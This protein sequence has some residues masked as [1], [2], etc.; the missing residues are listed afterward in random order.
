MSPVGSE[1]CRADGRKDLSKLVVP[2]RNCADSPKTVAFFLVLFYS[3]ATSSVSTSSS[4]L[5]SLLT[6]IT[7]F[8]RVSTLCALP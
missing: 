1:L 4:P 3:L 5:I 7:Y 6:L 8:S 2:V